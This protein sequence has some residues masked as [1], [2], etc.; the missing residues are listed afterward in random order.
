[1]NK[2]HK[3]PPEGSNRHRVLM[4]I[5][6]H[7]PMDLIGVLKLMPRLG[8]DAV[9]GALAGERNMGMLKFEDGVWSLESG[10]ESLLAP[11]E[12]KPVEKYVGE[13]VQPRDSSL[14][15]KPWSGRFSLANAPRRE[16]IRD[17]SFKTAGQAFM[18]WR[19]VA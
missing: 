15:S 2:D 6:Q 17:I 4:A 16:P 1:M 3:L 11:V 14:N 12:R 9:R 10:V 8:Y 19:E 7:G 5:H 13:V 18:P